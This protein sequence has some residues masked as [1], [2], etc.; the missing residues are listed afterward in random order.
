ML[1]GPAPAAR[2]AP[3]VS[4][5]AVPVSIDLAALAPLVEARVPSTFSGTAR[6]RGIDI[7]YDVARDAVSLRAIGAGLHASTRVRYAMQAC[8]GRFPCVSCGFGEPRREALVT[9]HSR[10]EWQPSWQLRS[11]TRL[12]PVHYPRPCEVTWFD[13]DVTHRFVAPVVERQ[14][15][16]AARVIDA[17]TP[18][19]TNIRTQAQQVWSALQK[20][21]EIAPRTWLTLEPSAVALS[22][23]H[24]SGATVTTTLALRA[25]TR[26]VVGARPQVTG[27]P[28]PPLQTGT[29]DEGRVRIP[30]DLELAYE[31]AGRI[32]SATLA[33]RTH[34]VNGRELVIES[35]RLR[36][37]GGGRVLVEATVDYR[38]GFLRN[39]R[40]EVFL[41]GTPLFDAPSAT[42]YFPDLEYSLAPERRG[43]LTRIVERAAH[44]SIRARLREATRFNL[45]P[46]LDELRAQLT[47]ALTRELAP[48]VR[49]AADVQTLEP[50]SVHAL[51]EV[52]VVR[53]VMSGKAEIKAGRLGSGF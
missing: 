21:I 33:G 6:E 31:D 2:P 45:R 9:L 11:T 37:A 48:G 18:R 47:T 10:L 8:R 5:I 35:L 19:L 25:L 34:R 23:I 29:A 46:R 22:P 16:A 51:G 1:P 27:K 32:A 53:V 36:P 39:Y 30:F 44:D 50:K 38:G 12:L 49:L 20:P 52:I 4:T 28:L 42:L 40:G 14:L 26:V 13:I 7:R 3:E 43:F 41:E 15:G 17:N 24:G